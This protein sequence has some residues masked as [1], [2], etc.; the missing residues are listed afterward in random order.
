MTKNVHQ[1]IGLKQPLLSHDEEGLADSNNDHLLSPLVE[2]VP[3]VEAAAAVVSEAEQ[4]E[5]EVA[6]PDHHHHQQQQQQQH[7]TAF[8]PHLNVIHRTSLRRGQWKDGIFNCC[9]HGCCH[10]SLV[11]PLCCPLSKF[12]FGVVVD[13]VV[14]TALSSFVLTL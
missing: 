3:V 10:P 5:Q 14:A 1:D 11:Y 6:T 12:F 9:T 13:D 7:S 8:P 2:A 4:G